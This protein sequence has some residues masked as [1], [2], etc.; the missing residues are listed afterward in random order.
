MEKGYL[1]KILALVLTCFILISCQEKEKELTTDDLLIDIE[2]ESALLDDKTP[3]K[4]D[5][6]EIKENE[7]SSVREIVEYYEWDWWKQKVTFKITFVD[8]KFNNVEAKAVTRNH[9]VTNYTKKFNNG[10]K[11]MVEWKKINEVQNISV[12]N[13][14]SLTTEAFKKAL[15]KMQKWEN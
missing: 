1:S 13:G 10:V 6:F 14:A 11:K 2:K 5:E 3:V 9:Y 12:I 7:I 8:N 4:I 15:I